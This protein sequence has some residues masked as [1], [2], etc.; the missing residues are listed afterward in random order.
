[1]FRAGQDRIGTDADE[2]VQG[3]DHPSLS[4]RFGADFAKAREEIELLADAAVP[5]D[6][7]AFLDA[8]QTPVFFGSAVN[9]FGVQ[10]VLDTLVERAPPPGPRVAMEREVRPEEPR[11]TGVV[12]KVQANMDPAHR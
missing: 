9:N 10:E 8:K 6:Q 7:Q 11:F 5:F 12:F 3:L 4:E 1:I 2:F